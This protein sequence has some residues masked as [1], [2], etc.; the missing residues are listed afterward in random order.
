MGADP[1]ALRELASLFAPRAK[2]FAVGGFCRDR[3]LGVT[4]RDLDV[5]SELGVEEVK[6]LLSTSRFEVSGKCMR[7]GTARIST[8]GFSAEYTAFRTDSYPDGSGVHRPVGV[9]FTRDMRA[10]AS[11]RDFTCNAVYFDPLTEEYTDFFGGREDIKAKV[12]RAVREPDGVFGEDGLRVLRLVRFAAELGFSPERE[13]FLSAKRNAAKVLDI[14]KERVFAELDKTFSA[15]TAYPELGVTDGHVRGLR[16]MDD[17]GLIDLLIPE[18]AA[19]R[20]LEQPRKY[21]VYDAYRHSVE[22]YAAAP[23]SVRWAALMHDIGKKPACDRQGNMHGHDVI[24][25]E[26]AFARLTAL[27]MPLRRAE[28]TA[29]LVRRH[30]IDLKGDMSE[31][32]LRLFLLE[33]TG[34]ADD[35]IALKRADAYATRGTDPGGLRIE[36]VWSEMRSDGTPLAVKDLPVDGRD[37]EEA[38]LHGKEI[39]DALSALLR[40]SAV[41]PVLRDRP[42]ALAFLKRRAEKAD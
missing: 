34:I 31:Q 1:A 8:E 30:M 38:G 36:R 16:L 33:H 42:R 41:N 6:T 25:A 14:T 29:E 19:L 7:L 10:D 15:D 11:R 22:A 20:G 32:K 18:L 37:A 26:L 21:H 39:G 24:G 23:P 40:E 12:L 4:P 17:I 35:L 27:G 5:C 13:T 9:T 3:L 2:L 28:R